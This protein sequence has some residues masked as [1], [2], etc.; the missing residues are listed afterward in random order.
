MFKTHKSITTT[1]L[2]ESTIPLEKRLHRSKYFMEEYPECVPIFVQYDADQTLH[3]YVVPKDNNFGHLLIAFRRKLTLKSS[4]GLMS[5]VE[6]VK[7]VDND[8]PKIDCFQVSS[9]STIRDLADKY[10]HDDGFLYVN[11]T[12]ENVFGF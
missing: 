8:K 11:V 12:T 7:V 6:K 1:E 3:R 10:I 9:S 5:L 2:V 4:I